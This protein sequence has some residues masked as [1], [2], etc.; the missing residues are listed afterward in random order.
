M[1]RRQLRYEFDWFPENKLTLGI[2]LFPSLVFVV[3]KSSLEPDERFWFPLQPG[4]S[5][6]AQTRY[7]TFVCY[8]VLQ[9]AFPQ[10]Q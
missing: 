8:D 10:N 5:R 9:T 1:L 7:D 6:A 4:G 2:L 3:F